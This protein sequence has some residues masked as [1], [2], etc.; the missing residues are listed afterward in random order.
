MK[1]VDGGCV[2]SYV[3]D[4]GPSPPLYIFFTTQTTIDFEI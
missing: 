3:C 1:V 4:D 2:V